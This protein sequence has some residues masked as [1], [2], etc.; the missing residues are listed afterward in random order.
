MLGSH[1]AL[2]EAPA[3]SHSL[4]RP[5]PPLPLPP[6]SSRWLSGEGRL[7]F[8]LNTAPLTP[9]H[10]PIPAQGAPSAAPHQHTP[11]SVLAVG[12]SS[13]DTFT[14]SRLPSAGQVR[15]RNCHISRGQATPRVRKQ[16]TRQRATEPQKGWGCG[17][18]ERWGGVGWQREGW[19]KVDPRRAPAAHPETR[20]HSPHFRER[21]HSLPLTPLWKTPSPRHGHPELSGTDA[22]ST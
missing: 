13:W 6:G 7:V 4:G 3:D 16:D 22:Q 8:S 9:T 20:L 17:H 19:G 15:R 14:Y 5:L 21:S 1:Q 11:G 12:C 2:S 18:T 10:P